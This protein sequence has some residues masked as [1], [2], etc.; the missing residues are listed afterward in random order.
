MVVVHMSQFEKI[1]YVLALI[2]TECNR[3]RI[4]AR[5]NAYIP[6]SNGGSRLWLGLTYGYGHQHLYVKS[7]A[8]IRQT[9]CLLKAVEISKPAAPAILD[10]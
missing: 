10:S 3:T 7:V 8:Y 1:T 2:F 4:C 5:H 6:H 9:W